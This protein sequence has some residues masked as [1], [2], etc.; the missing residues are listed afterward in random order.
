YRISASA[1]GFVSASASVA[2]VDNDL[3]SVH[4]DIANHQVSESAGPQATVATVTRT[5]VSDRTL[6]VQ[7]T[8]SDSASATV[9]PLVTIA[10][11][12]ASATFFVAVADNAVVDGP[13]H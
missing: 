2:V 1:T 5:P 11:N 13:R 9:P 12:Q 7:L 6:V 10:A 8:S 4:V 3:P